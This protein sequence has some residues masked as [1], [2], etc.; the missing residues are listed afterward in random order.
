MSGLLSYYIS[1]SQE[2]ILYVHINFRLLQKVFFLTLRRG[3]INFRYSEFK[4][5]GR[6]FP[7]NLNKNK[8][9][10]LVH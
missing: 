2:V 6:K 5:L 10:L 1:L 8:K 7:C 4:F 9:N 3:R